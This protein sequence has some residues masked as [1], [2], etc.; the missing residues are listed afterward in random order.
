MNSVYGLLSTE[1]LYCLPN[2]IG[3]A[4]LP[5]YLGCVYAAVPTVSKKPVIIV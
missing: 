1:S 3:S 5:Y 2:V 4:Y